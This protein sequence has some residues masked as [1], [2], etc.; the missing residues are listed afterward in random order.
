MCADSRSVS[1]SESSGDSSAMP[2]SASPA[3]HETCCQRGHAVSAPAEDPHGAHVQRRRAGRAG[4]RGEIH[5]PRSSESGSSTSAAAA[6]ADRDP[7]EPQDQD[8]DGQDGQ[9]VD[10]H[11]AGVGEREGHWFACESRNRPKVVKA[12]ITASIQYCEVVA[13]RAFPYS[14]SARSWARTGRR[15]GRPPARR[16]ARTRSP[17]AP[18]TP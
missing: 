13:V 4:K 17:V 8:E 9:Q 6:V 18:I 14:A 11:V 1:P 2:I 15:R 12:T 10:E 3:N 5:R 7:H 16:P